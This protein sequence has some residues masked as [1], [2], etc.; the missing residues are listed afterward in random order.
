MDVIEESNVF[1]RTN[2]LV[3]KVWFVIPKWRRSVEM[4]GVFENEKICESVPGKEAK[5]TFV[6]R[7]LL[8]CSSSEW[9]AIE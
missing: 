7:R 5:Q 4:R 6:G 9:V 2:D 3:M 8:F 1:R